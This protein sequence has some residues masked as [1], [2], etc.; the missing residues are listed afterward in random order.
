MVAGAVVPLGVA[1]SHPLPPA[2]YVIEVLR[3]VNV[4]VPEL[5]TA[6]LV[7]DGSGPPCHV[8]KLVD[9]GVSEIVGRGPTVRLTDARLGLLPTPAEEEATLTVAL[10]VPGGS[11][12]GAAVNVMVAGAAVELIAA[13]SQPLPP[14]E[15]ET[16]VDRP[17]NVPVPTLFTTM[18][19]VA[20]AVAAVS[21][22]ATFV[23]ES[24]MAGGEVTFIVNVNGAP[25]TSSAAVT[26]TVAAYVIPAASPTL[27][28]SSVM[29]SPLND[30]VSQAEP[31]PE[32]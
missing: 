24:P 3:P 19:T 27:D 18:G 5:A 28:A 6:T 17:A 7:A 12:A 25:T 10:Y 30:G 26:V 14:P 1:D 22:R 4:P 9:V 15:Y 11:A 2:P 20:G 16:D 32:V 23:G 31:P 13:A 21:K 8:A 29:V